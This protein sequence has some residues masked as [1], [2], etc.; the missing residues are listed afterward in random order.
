[1]SLAVPGYILAVSPPDR[2]EPPLLPTQ[3]PHLFVREGFA[4]RAQFSAS[5][6]DTWYGCNFAWGLRYLLGLRKPEPLWGLD[7]AH[8][9]PRDRS[10]AFGKALHSR[11]EDYFCGRPVDWT[12]EI[13]SRALDALPYLPQQPPVVTEQPIAF[14]SRRVLGNLERPVAFVG[15]KDLVSPEI[16]YDY[17]T[18]GQVGGRYQKKAG[19]LIQDPAANLYLLDDMNRLGTHERKGRWVYVQSKGPHKSEPVDFT[20]TRERAE[21][22]VRMMIVQGAVLREEI[23][24]F[25]SLQG[26]DLVD[27]LGHLVKNTNTCKKYNGCVYHHSAGG[28]CR[29]ELAQNYTIPA[30]SLTGVT[31]QNHETQ[32]THEQGHTSM[33]NAPPMSIQDRL[34]AS[35][36]A[37]QQQQAPAASQA[38]QAPQ[39][40]AP[41]N[42]HG[43]GFAPP[44]QPGGFPPA[45]Q[46]GFAPHGM[47]AG[48]PA[49]PPPAPSFPSAPP[50]PQQ[51]PPPVAPGQQ[52]PPFGGFGP[53]AQAPFMGSP[54]QS[55]AAPPGA[56]QLPAT[57]PK[58]TRRTKAQIEAEKAAAQGAPTGG[59]TPNTISEVPP[60]S[61]DEEEDEDTPPVRLLVTLDL[62]NG[63]IHT[64]EAPPDATDY[65]L[66]IVIAKSK[67]ALG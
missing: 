61:S 17:K 3:W 44:P 43:Q 34:N 41:F 53:T 28:P 37:A 39:G 35:R 18:T 25:N 60:G 66:G 57:A 47:P 11:L 21:P 58:R 46:Q 40:Q 32:T 59:F 29:A 9:D 50:V 33:S 38:P 67:A 30:G 51:G 23:E 10:L 56:P 19:D 48:Q 15:F 55:F 8:L 2:P 62:G 13:G 22:I 14:D 26:L 1:M 31:E 20:I 7:G 12:D 4:P 52:A 45:P 16:T 63:E 49:G 54:E 6:L 65:L 36:Q 64:V 24:R 42:P 5:Q 27:A